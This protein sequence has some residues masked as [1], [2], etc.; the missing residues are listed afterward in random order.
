MRSTLT[1]RTG[2][3]GLTDGTALSG[4]GDEPVQNG[5]ELVFIGTGLRKD[6]LTVALTECLLDGAEHAAGPRAWTAFEDPFPAWDEYAI[7]DDHDHEH[8]ALT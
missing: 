4:L 5:Q 6:E 3:G 2:L 1:E 8:A 7:Q